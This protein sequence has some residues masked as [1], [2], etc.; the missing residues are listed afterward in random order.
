MPEHKRVYRNVAGFEK[1]FTFTSMLKAYKYAILP[2]EEQKSQLANFF[3]SVRFVYN[4]GL[5][6]KLQAWASG[7]KH[8]TCI[9]LANQMI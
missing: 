9:D 2:T 1:S 7:R 4:L 3:G 6:T 8:L 5:E